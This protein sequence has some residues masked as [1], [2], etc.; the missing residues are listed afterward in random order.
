MINEERTHMLGIMFIFV[1]RGPNCIASFDNPHM[2]RIMHLYLSD[3]AMQVNYQHKVY[4][5]IVT[6]SILF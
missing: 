2:I 3:V 5:T 1:T 6:P 4:E